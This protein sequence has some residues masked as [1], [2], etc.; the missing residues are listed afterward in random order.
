MKKVVVKI[1]PNKKTMALVSV[2]KKNPEKGFIQLEQ[3]VQKLSING[4][5]EP[6]KRTTLIKGPVSVLAEIVKESKD[7]AVPYSLEGRLI[8]KEF[9]ENNIPEFYKKLFFNKTLS[10]ADQLKEFVK[11]AGNGG[12]ALKHKG[13]R[14]VKFTILDADCTEDDVKVEHDNHAEIQA[15]NAAKS[16]GLSAKVAGLPTNSEEEEVTSVE[17][18]EETGG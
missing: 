13:E 1:V 11:T 9:T 7:N 15:F 4:W 8:V 5:I 17:P 14:I 6:V 2:F 12:P 16:Q 10:P 3:V 18:S